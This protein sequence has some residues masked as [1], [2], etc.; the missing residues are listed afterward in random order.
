MLPD[1]FR[2][3]FSWHDQVLADFRHPVISSVQLLPYSPQCMPRQWVH[4]CGTHLFAVGTSSGADGRVSRQRSTSPTAIVS[5][6]SSLSRI[7]S[8]ESLRTGAVGRVSRPRTSTSSAS[9]LTR[10]AL[11]FSP[12]LR[13]PRRITGTG[14]LGLVRVCVPFNK[15]S[16]VCWSSISKFGEM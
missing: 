13:L 16:L 9:L 14:R 10:F 1:F 8:A 12:A 7:A 2:D 5:S 15:G 3:E 4:D 6:T 11:S